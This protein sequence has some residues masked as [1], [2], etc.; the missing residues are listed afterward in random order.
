MANITRRTGY[1][2]VP[3]RA[4]A[5]VADEGPPV[6]EAADAEEI[7]QRRKSSFWIALFS[8]FF[9]SI[10]HYFL[11]SYHDAAAQISRTQGSR[12]RFRLLCTIVGM[13]IVEER[14]RSAKR[15]KEISG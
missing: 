3:G 12:T 13:S 7:M 6:R 8:I 1:G 11:I 2:G 15:I 14:R 5:A 4:T 10:S 9:R